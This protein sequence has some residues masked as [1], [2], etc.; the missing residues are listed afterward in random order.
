VVGLWS[1]F[2]VPA[3][4]PKPVID[5][6]SRELRDVILNTPVRDQLIGMAVNPAGNSPD[7][8]RH[9]IAEEIKMWQAVVTEGNL[10][11]SE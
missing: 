11:F 6:L 2:F 8:F 10:K 5:K 9:L 1:G 7:E 4:T 3:G